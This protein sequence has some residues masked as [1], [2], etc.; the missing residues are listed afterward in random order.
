M[1][2]TPPPPLNLLEPGVLL[3]GALFGSL[4]DQLHNGDRLPP[5]TR[6]GPFRIGE[7][8]GRGGMGMVYRAERDD[9]EYRQSVAIKCLATS[10]SAQS[11]EL[12]RR[13][14]QVLAELKHPHIARLLDGG[15]HVDGRLWFAMELIEGRHIDEHVRA[16]RL[17][18]AERVRLLRQVIDA[19]AFAHQR[20]IVH[21]DIKPGN[22]L[23]DADGGVKLLDFG[24]SAL[25]EDETAARAY[26]P[27]WASPEQ[28]A[29]LE[30]GPASDQF[31]I[32]LLLDVMLRG[33]VAGSDPDN[34]DAATATE[35]EHQT[36][37]HEVGE[38]S[39][40]ASRIAPA[41]WMPMAPA[42]STELAAIAARATA[43]KE[44]ARY[45]SVAELGAELDR[46]LDLRPVIAHGGGIAYSVRCGVR[47]HPLFATFVL[48]TTL[49]IAALV[50]G[51]GWRLARE[52]DLARAA[53]ARAE[54]AAATAQAINQFLN[55]DLLGSAD[56]YGENQ[57]KVP[58]GEL[59]E[60]AVPRVAARLHD[61]PAV[62]AEIYLVLGKS[63]SSLGQLES[64]A[65]ALDLAIAHFSG[66]YGGNA[67][68]SLQARLQRLIVEDNAQRSDAYSAGLESLAK[69]AEALGAAHPLVVEIAAHRAWAAFALGEFAIAETLG[70]EALTRASRSPGLRPTVL[71]D[72]LLVQA[73]TLMRLQ[74]APEAL[75]PAERAYRLRRDT[76][77]A[78][79]IETW[80]A[81]AQWA[82]AQLA[83]GEVEQGLAKL[84]TVYARVREHFGELH[85]QTLAAAHQL[86]LALIRSDRFEQAI[87]PL[88]AAVAGKS[89]SFGALSGPAVASASV[90]GYALT[91]AGRL[92]EADE[93]FAGLAGYAPKTSYDQ[94]TLANL[95]SNR[96]ELALAQG[97][98]AAADQW[99]RQ[100][101]QVTEQFASA[102]R[103]LSSI[104]TCL[105]LSAAEFG[106]SARARELL[107]RQQKT[108][109]ELGAKGAYQLQRIDAALRKLEE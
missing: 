74:R 61:R 55:E 105:G 19:V 6:L 31:Q 95:L 41:E 28:L 30:I 21:R 46:W 25:I 80:M 9:G 48:I 35:I 33:E 83:T 18:V 109:R 106:Q 91:R 34:I 101:L 8:I 69:D 11:L 51:F 102:A 49:G 10:G 50:A 76:L 78:D 26:S 70:D 92:D 103:Y 87:A 66:S 45:G 53:A 104:E 96:G 22:V 7:E 65:S 59:L 2:D 20:L 1:P 99:C 4:I 52:R 54:H 89:R 56:P 94:R 73:L 14:R 24:I 38:K 82:N 3:G 23:V 44:D 93:L 15:H 68:R 77:G 29:G 47:R 85:N 86:G 42:R 84:T 27:A 16:A 71:A 36:S 63:L 90:L 13:E 64:A 108:W 5:G 79:A 107:H 81:E 39:S 100:G 75:Q 40:D 17:S 88:R 62:A 98:W 12:F 43:R 57:A 60:Q 72:M 32:G 97:N 67:E 58:I 37:L